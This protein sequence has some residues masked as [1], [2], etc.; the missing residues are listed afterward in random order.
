MPIWVRSWIASP[1]A[2]IASSAGWIWLQP[3][4]GA[5]FPASPTLIERVFEKRQMEE[6]RLAVPIGLLHR[7]PRRGLQ[8]FL[9]LLLPE[10]GHGGGAVAACLLARRDEIEGAVLHPLD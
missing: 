5:K 7:P 9:Q 10:L 4:H 2:S 8:Q 6:R 3:R 1:T